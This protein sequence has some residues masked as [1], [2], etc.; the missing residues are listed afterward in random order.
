MR[1]LGIGWYFAMTIVGG[2]AGGFLLDTWL[3]TRPLFTVLGL[4]LGLALALFGG[5]VLLMRVL[6]EDKT[7]KGKN[8]T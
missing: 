4:F 7:G 8:E 3:Q 6:T 5:Y 1:L 2:I